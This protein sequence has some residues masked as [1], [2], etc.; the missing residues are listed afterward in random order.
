MLRN[1]KTGHMVATVR[2]PGST[3]T[4]DNPIGQSDCT[5]S[6]DTFETFVRALDRLDRAT[7]APA[8]PAPTKWF[9]FTGLPLVQCGRGADEQ[10]RAY[11]ELRARRYPAATYVEVDGEPTTRELQL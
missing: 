7:G 3:K 1:V 5:I 6:D 4:I 8:E 9:M 10:A 11:T 2:R